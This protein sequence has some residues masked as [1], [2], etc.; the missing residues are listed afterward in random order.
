MNKRIIA[1]RRDD[2]YS[3]NSVEK[4]RCILLDAA[5]RL[6]G[7]CPQASL[8]IIDEHELPKFI[9]E[10]KYEE[11][12]AYVV[13]NMARSTEALQA[14]SMMEQEG[15]LVVNS[16]EGVSR[17]QRSMLD[18][19][20]RDNDVAMPPLEG[21]D[22]YWLKRGDAAAQ[23]HGDVVFCADTK[24]LETAKEDF[25][26]RG[27]TN[28][29]TS[30]HVVGDVVK[31]YGVGR[32]F[33]RYFYPTDDHITKFGDEAKNGKA[34]HYPFS[35]HLLSEEAQRLASIVGVS[36]FGGDAVV[37]ADG[38]IAIIDFNDWP[39]F[40]RCREEAADAIAIEITEKMK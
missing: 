34:H 35:E 6:R 10:A 22:G 1:V 5:K 39:S 21:T 3:P 32:R 27:I 23:E 36:V 11:S 17:C 13:L 2:R 8:T 25:R 15:V 37:R 33:F 19:I 7:K 26:R 24:A 4:D 18:R 31:F 20:M 30:A 16:A 9:S 38:T 14:L 12:T 28:W 40:S 29:V